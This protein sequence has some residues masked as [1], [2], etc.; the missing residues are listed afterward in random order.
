MNGGGSFLKAGVGVPGKK[1]LCLLHSVEPR[2]APGRGSP[3]ES[4]R[5]LHL[6]THDGNSFC[7]Q[8]VALVHVATTMGTRRSMGVRG[9]HV[10]DFSGKDTDL[11]REETHLR[12]QVH[13]FKQVLS[14]F[15]P[16]SPLPVSTGS[17]FPCSWGSPDIRN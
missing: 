3:W 14:C 13:I 10:P 2:P 11:R 8:A 4:P 9:H 6:L 7:F 17:H 1:T 5:K 15:S 12:S 16:C